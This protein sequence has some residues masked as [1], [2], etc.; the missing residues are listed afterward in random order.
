[1]R[2]SLAAEQFLSQPRIAVTGVSRTS[3]GHGS[4][5]V[6]R[7]LR[8]RGFDAVAIN[9]NAT[10]VE[11]DR[12]C[13]SLTSVPGG[14]Q[15]VVIGTNP[16]RASDTVREC[17]ELGVRYIWMH[18]GMGA[19]SVSPEATALARSHGLLV[20][21]GGCP[22]MFGATSDPFHRFVKMLQVARGTLPR[23]VQAANPQ[24]DRASGSTSR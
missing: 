10:T 4:N 23:D 18:H 22:C 7:R 8:E 6:Y 9:P 14:V 1:M 3:K 17:I 5:V 12:C 2:T 21:D 11:G 13:P 19:G 24:G 16:D 15:A 20:I